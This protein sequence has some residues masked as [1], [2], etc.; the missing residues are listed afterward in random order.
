MDNLFCSGDFRE[1]RKRKRGW[2]V[3]CHIHFAYF[4][5]DSLVIH[6]QRWIQ[7]PH[8][9]SQHRWFPLKS[10]ICGKTC[11]VILKM[12]RLT[13]S[14]FLGFFTTL[15][16]LDTTAKSI[17]IDSSLSGLCHAPNQLGALNSLRIVSINDKHLR[18]SHGR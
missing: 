3:P 14:S 1:E 5:G 16:T 9:T 17:L 2:S 18:S 7:N 10:H 15:L 12:T 8:K 4:S 13:V 6:P 11:P